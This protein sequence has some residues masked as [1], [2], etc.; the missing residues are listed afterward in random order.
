MKTSKDDRLKGQSIEE[1]PVLH[2]QNRYDAFPYKKPELRLSVPQSFGRFHGLSH[3]PKKGY[4]RQYD[5]R[6]VLRIPAFL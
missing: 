6:I 5:L 4:Q 2:K 3:L 1:L